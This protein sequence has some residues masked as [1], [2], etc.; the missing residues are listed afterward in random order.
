M[1]THHICKKYTQESA[2]VST[3][4]GYLLHPAAEYLKNKNA[5]LPKHDALLL[6]D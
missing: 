1:Q 3:S 5:A 6:L 2:V 4:A